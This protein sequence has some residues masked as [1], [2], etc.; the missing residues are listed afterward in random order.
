MGQTSAGDCSC[1]DQTYLVGLGSKMEC[2]NCPVGAE[3]HDRTCALRTV[4]FSCAIVGEWTKDISV[5]EYS[6][7]A[8]PV[9][10]KLENSSTMGLNIGCR[11]CPDGYYVHNPLDPNDVF[12]KC[13][14]A[15]V[16]TNGRAPIF[17]A[18]KM[19]AAFEIELPEVC[20][21]VA[22]KK[23][24]AVQLGVEA[25]TLV[26]AADPCGKAQRR[27]KRMIT[28]AIVGKSSELAGLQARISKMGAVTFGE[29]QTEGLQVLEG[30][31][32]EQLG[33]VYYLRQCP[34]GNLLINT[35]I[36]VQECKQ[37]LPGTYLLEGSSECTKCPEGADCP[38]GL[39]FVSRVEGAQW[40]KELATDGTGT[41]RLR[42]TECPAGYALV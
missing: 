40:T 10:Y 25:F 14:S 15:A 4:P 20:S 32:W 5:G 23:A 6:V 9:G 16:C 27:A 37:C 11:K 33:G 12:R 19:D 36:E 17:N 42:I 7:V 29:V 22:V 8:C 21:D 13:P 3:C 30:E 26:L 34:S 39:S 2:L 1:P 24:L 38:D 41:R 18:V 28:F 35:T 31:F